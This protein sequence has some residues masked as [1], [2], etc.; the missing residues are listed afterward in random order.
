MHDTEITKALWQIAP[1]DTSAVAV[2]H[3][4]DEQAI[5]FCSGSWLACLA[6]QQMADARPLG[7]KQCVS[8]THCSYLALGP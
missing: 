8:F 3:R 4:I 7:F 5:V 6:G 2:E 1:R